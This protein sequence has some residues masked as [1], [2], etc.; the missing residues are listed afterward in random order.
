M[1]VHYGV[2]M[3]RLFLGLKMS[4]HYVHY[5]AWNILGSENVQVLWP[6]NVWPFNVRPFSGHTL[7]S[8]V[9]LKGL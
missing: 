7:H 5:N 6:C 3:C 8:N 4:V 1:S 2:I 9:V